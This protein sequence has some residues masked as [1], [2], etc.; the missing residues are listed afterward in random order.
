[1]PGC[2]GGGAG[3]LPGDA[4]VATAT[5][6]C[7]YHGAIVRR[8]LGIVLVVLVL[9]GGL[10]VLRHQGRG[11]PGDADPEHGETQAQDCE[12]GP[13]A[14]PG[15]PTTPGARVRPDLPQW[16]TPGQREIL[17]RIARFET[18]D[19][20][21]RPF[22]RVQTGAWIQ[23]QGSEPRP[24]RSMGFL[25][26]D[27]GEQFT[28]QHLDLRTQTYS[29]LRSGPE[30]EQVWFETV[31]LA[32]WTRER[33]AR[34]IEDLH[35]LGPSDLMARAG[36]SLRV[37]LLCAWLGLQ[38]EANLLWSTLDTGAALSDFQ[39]AVDALLVMAVMDR[40]VSW[41]ELLAR[42]ELFL[43][44]FPDA[45][46]ARSVRARAEV[47]RRMTGGGDA[48]PGGTLDEGPALRAQLAEVSGLRE[49]NLG[50]WWCMEPDEDPVSHRILQGIR[51]RGREAVQELI[52]LIGDESLSRTVYYFSRYGGS[53]WVMTVGE[54]AEALL[55][56]IT[57]EG[58][59]GSVDE[60]VRKWKAWLEEEVATPEQRHR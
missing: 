28:V 29:V 17:E 40:G 18:I 55:S 1:M 27:S 43:Q 10:A 44:I 20:R 53:L 57:G 8:N 48:E 13:V 56:E 38:E 33:A 35:Y 22:V 31:D 34:E 51:D 50:E 7:W 19:P 37:T 11:E 58:F 2:A 49:G 39:C 16:V 5:R 24:V 14:A 47:L 60:R 6:W 3:A 41:P 9:L 45:Y 15:V 54:H 59:S 12:P 23:Y 30:H 46:S 25:L 36:V 4:V 32:D 21:G 26:Q 42:H 52:Q